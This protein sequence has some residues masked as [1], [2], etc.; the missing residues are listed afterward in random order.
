MKFIKKE[1]KILISL[2][3]IIGITSLFFVS[4]ANGQTSDNLSNV[5]KPN[6]A[7]FNPE[8]SNVNHSPVYPDS[9]NT[10]YIS[11]TITDEDGLSSTALFY[12]EQG[13]STFNLTGLTQEGSTDVYGTPI[14]PYGAGTVI[15]YYIYAVDNSPSHYTTTDDNFGEYYSFIVYLADYEAPTITNVQHSPETPTEEDLIVISCTVTDLS[16]VIVKLNFRVDESEWANQTMTNT[17]GNDYSTT[18]G[19][20][21]AGTLFEYRIYAIDQS[22]YNNTNLE[23]AEGENYY[24]TVVVNDLEAPN[25]VDILLDP[26]TVLSGQTVIITCTVTDADN[27][28]LNVTLYYRING[29]DWVQ[30]SMNLVEAY[31]VT[32]GP[33]ETDDLIEFY[34][35]AFDDSTNT[36]SRTNDNGGSYY[37]FTVLEN[38]E[39]ASLFVLMPIL[40]LTALSIIYR[41]KK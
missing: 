12:R 7:N 40:S 39:E 26:D 38:P 9:C 21:A 28:I 37:S 1:V 31:E 3:V 14:G 18:V 30:A 22:I 16:D 32:I 29:G 5:V 35:V 19:E 36:N 41:K 13:D 4:F 10:I 24:F 20:F 34:V 23:N 6:V 33:F 11:A 25:I 27:G 15:E 2:I 8:I 17:E